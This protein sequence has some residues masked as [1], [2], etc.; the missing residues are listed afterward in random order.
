MKNSLQVLENAGSTHPA[1]NTHGH[2]SI[3][4][5]PA[6][7][8][9]NNCRCKLCSSAAQ[10]MSQSNS[11]AVG[12]HLGRIKPSFLDHGQCLR[13]KRLVQLDHINIFQL[14]SCYL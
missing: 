5:V 8:L 3:A 7:E 11:A 4:S 10:W 12:I 13:G 14:Q 2:N 9:A 6:L 1:A